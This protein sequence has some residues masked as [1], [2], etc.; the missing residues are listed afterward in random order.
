[1]RRQ[2]SFVIGVVALALAGIVYTFAAGNEPLLGLDLQGGASVV[3]EPE[4]NPDGTPVSEDILDQA[5][6]VIRNR[7]D[8]LGVREPEITRQG[9]TVLVQIPGVDD[10][11]RALELVGQTAELRFR[12]VLDSLGP[13]GQLIYDSSLAIIESADDPD[14]EVDE[15]TLAEAQAFVDRWALTP[16]PVGSGGLPRCFRRSPPT[17]KPMN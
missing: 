12:P 8:G 3:L 9:Q 10:Q 4:P 13:D 2:A 15:A 1:M 7:I 5:I 6:D 17:P 14:S 11:A 16:D